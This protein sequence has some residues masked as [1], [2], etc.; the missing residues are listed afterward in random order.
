VLER[1]G[2]IVQNVDAAGDLGPGVTAAAQMAYSCSRAV[3]VL[4]SQRMIGAKKFE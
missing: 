2:V 3:A 1:S 4:I